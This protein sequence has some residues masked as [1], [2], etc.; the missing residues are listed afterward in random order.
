M[1]VAAHGFFAAT[2]AV[3]LIVVGRRYAQLP[4]RVSLNVDF[5]GRPVGSWPRPFIWLPVAIFI[6]VDAI[7]MAVP[8]SERDIKPIPG[9]VIEL[10]LIALAVAYLFSQSIDVSLG[11]RTLV[12][13]RALALLVV[14]SL[15]SVAV[16]AFVFSGP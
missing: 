15:A 8:Q 11:K 16:N 4:A 12:S 6:G 10:G 2:I 9:V 1:L 14:V 3:F 7:L 13:R 5:R